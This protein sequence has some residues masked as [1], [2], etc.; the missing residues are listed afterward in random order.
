MNPLDQMRT[1]S[2]VE[3][4][5][6]LLCAVC[7]R[8]GTVQ[9]LDILTATHEGLQQAICFLRME[10]VDSEQRLMKSLGIGRF[11]GE[12]VLVI[13][14]ESPPVEAHTRPS[15]QWADFGVM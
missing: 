10:S 6:A 5:R 12:L 7:E 1:C 8:Y 15:S 9:R 14:L 2:S 11:G 13:D 4:L 3:A